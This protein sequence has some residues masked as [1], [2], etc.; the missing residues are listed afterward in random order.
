MALFPLTRKRRLNNYSKINLLFSSVFVAC[1]LTLNFSNVILSLTRINLVDRDDGQVVVQQQQQQ[2]QVETIDISTT[3]PSSVLA[4][5]S[6]VEISAPPFQPSTHQCAI[7][8]TTSYNLTMLHDLDRSIPNPSSS[9]SSPRRR[10]I[11]PVLYQTAKEKCILSSMYETTIRRWIQP[12]SSHP[13]SDHDHDTD[14]EWW[15]SYRFYDDERMEKYLLQPQ[16]K[17]LFPSLS[18]ALKCINHVNMPVMKADL[19]RYLILWEYGGIFADLDVLPVMTTTKANTGANATLGLPPLLQELK[20]GY[21]EHNNNN[22]NNNDRKHDGTESDDD[23]HHLDDALFVLVNTAGQQVLSQW[24]M[25]VA[26]RH[27]LMYYAI[28]EATYR[29]L[30]AKRAIPIQQTGPRALYDA[31]D[32]FLQYSNESSSQSRHLEVGRLYLG[33]GNDD[34]KLTLGRSQPRLRRSFRVL[35]ASWAQNNAFQDIKRQAY[36]WMN[37]TH[38]SDQQHRHQKKN[39][40][41][42]QQPQQQQQSSLATNG[43]N[44]S[45]RRPYNGTSCLEF[46]GGKFLPNSHDMNGAVSSYEYEQMTYRFRNPM[47]EKMMG[48]S[49]TL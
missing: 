5:S 30:Q 38:Y 43:D 35:P 3:T 7:P 27:P 32:R 24:F 23:S 29:V 12:P 1:V 31:T 28:E 21:Q 25:A 18:L 4:S 17:E 11:P 10:K 49:T 26:P 36:Q 41:Q 8:S 47:P 20:N 44:D 45:R 48:W 9:S 13:S 16:W 2:E 37:M 6:S 22:N 40:Q 42:Q 14:L 33:E 34:D 15:L 19:W 46:L 39:L